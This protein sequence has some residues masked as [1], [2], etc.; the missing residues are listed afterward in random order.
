MIRGPVGEDPLALHLLLPKPKLKRPLFPFISG[1][2]PTL[3]V[4]DPVSECH[5]S[6]KKPAVA[7]LGPNLR[8][9]FGCF[10][11]GEVFLDK[12]PPRFQTH[13]GPKE[14]MPLIVIGTRLLQGNLDP[15]RAVGLPKSPAICGEK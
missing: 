11:L 5:F 1:Q 12:R 7:Y 10:P 8:S 2:P 4:S 6:L 15:G 13:Q 9:V 3:D 14:M